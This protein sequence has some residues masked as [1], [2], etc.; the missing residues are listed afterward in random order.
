MAATFTDL[1]DGQSRMIVADG[2]QAVVVY[3]VVNG[4]VFEAARFMDES[5]F[6]SFTSPPT[7]MY[8]LDSGRYRGFL[9]NRASGLMWADDPQSAIAQ[10]TTPNTHT[11]S[12]VTLT[13]GANIAVWNN[14]LIALEAGS[15]DRIPIA[16]N[17]VASVA[18]SLNYFYVS[19]VDAFTTFSIAGQQQVAR[20]D[21]VGGGSHP[22][23]I[24]P[25]GHV[26]AIASNI[27]FIFP[28]PRT[29]AM[30]GEPLVQE[31]LNR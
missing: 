7:V 31:A 23:A 22:P 10:Y 17:S 28:P 25:K 27:L 11:A 16:G 30:I 4:S 5:A 15:T 26:Y 18:A 2:Y 9:V 6:R 14:E 20:F 24:G 19:S 12:S 1:T 21:W 8:E 29:T 3:K 13:A